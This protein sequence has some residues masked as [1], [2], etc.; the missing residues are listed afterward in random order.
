MSHPIEQVV[1]E[2][3]ETQIRYKVK[4]KVFVEA[5]GDGRLG[6]EAGV[7]YVIGREG[8]EFNEQL[9]LN[10]SDHETMGS[11]IYFTAEDA[12]RPMSFTPP[13]W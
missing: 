13:P 11:S 12:G 8:K 4:G 3:Q 10:E 5:T 1:A 2:N 7:P 6:V 9:A